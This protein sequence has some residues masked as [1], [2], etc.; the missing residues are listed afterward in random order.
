MRTKDITQIINGRNVFLAK[1][2]ITCYRCGNEFPPLEINN[3]ICKNCIDIINQLD[4]K[5]LE[6]LN[7]MSKDELVKLV[8]ELEFKED[9]N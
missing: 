9:Y 6:E 3:D 8:L 1:E 7:S 5:H 4:K 2:T